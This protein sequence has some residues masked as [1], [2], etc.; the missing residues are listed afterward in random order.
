M[1]YS[2]LARSGS[3]GQGIKCFKKTGKSALRSHGGSLFSF[4]VADLYK[5]VCS[6][7]PIIRQC[8]VE[9]IIGVEFST[10]NYANKGT[11]KYIS[12]QFVWNSISELT[13]RRNIRSGIP[14]LTR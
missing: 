5:Y 13:L 3:E 1:L 9:Q 7:L 14:E 4:S 11:R 6:T 10:P 12:T 2:L 8:D